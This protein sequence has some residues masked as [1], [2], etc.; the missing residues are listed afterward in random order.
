M[1]SFRSSAKQAQHALKQL[2]N[3]GQS[4]HKDRASG[5]IHSLGTER[6]YRQALTG[7][8]NWIKENKLGSLRDLDTEKAMRYLEQRSEEV[9]QKTLDLDRQAMQAYLGEKIPT[10]KSEL[11]TAQ[12]SRAYTKEQAALI[13]SAQRERNA[14]A[15][16]IA[17]NAGLRAHELFTL[18]PLQERAASS[19]REF[20]AERFAGRQ[21]VRIYTVKGKGGLVREVAIDKHLAERLEARR[22]EAPVRVTDRGIHYHSS[23]DIAGG[24]RWSNS[25]S[26]A[27]T[28]ELGWSTGAH[29]LRHTYA[30]GRMHELQGGGRTYRD[31]LGIVSQE[32][33]HFRE[34]IT[35]VYLR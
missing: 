9:G 3:H 12:E 25:F 6:N 18:L 31:A 8:T 7:V 23:Y 24:Q 5:K 21:D 15:T 11:Q 26:Q 16:E 10:I 30:Q 35:E 13:A 4:R 14:L 29:G 28:R 19:H 1:P 2:A 32:M 17:H 22:L 20:S 27:S 34:S 33:G